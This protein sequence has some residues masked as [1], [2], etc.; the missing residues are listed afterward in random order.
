MHMPAIE[1]IETPKKE[2]RK[3]RSDTMRDAFE[4]SLTNPNTKRGRLYWLVQRALDR[5]S[6]H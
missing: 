3:P 1:T 2:R 6:H 4:R 5:K